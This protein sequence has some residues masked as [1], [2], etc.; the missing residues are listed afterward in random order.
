MAVESRPGISLSEI[1]G[2]G[3]VWRATKAVTAVTGVGISLSV[4][5]GSGLVGVDGMTASVANSTFCKCEF[6]DLL[7]NYFPKM[8][9][10]HIYNKKNRDKHT[11]R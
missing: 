9:C 1:S 8:P 2:S 6:R 5:S 11:Y 4:I 3:L 10:L 7:A